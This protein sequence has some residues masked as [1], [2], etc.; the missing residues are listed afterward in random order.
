M[1]G[2][3]QGFTFTSGHG[4]EMLEAISYIEAGRSS[5]PQIHTQ[6]LSH[7]KQLHRLPCDAL[8]ESYQTRISSIERT[9]Q[10]KLLE[11]EAAQ[12]ES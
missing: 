11:S 5:I 9:D 3:S 6:L 4:I 10:P 1:V 7:Y 8:R 2:I 12:Q